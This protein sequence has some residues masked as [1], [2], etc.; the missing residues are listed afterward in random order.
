MREGKV[1]VTDEST[2][3]KYFINPYVHIVKANE[4]NVDVTMVQKLW[5][6]GYPYAEEFMA[7]LSNPVTI[8]PFADCMVKKDILGLVIDEQD[9]LLIYE[10]YALSQDPILST[11]KD[12][13]G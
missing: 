13:N 9:F 7:Y 3:L 6:K 5:A 4:K 2:Y 1:F 10:D 12:I 8:H 11:V